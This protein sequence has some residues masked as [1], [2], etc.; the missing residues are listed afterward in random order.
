M[1][2][3]QLLELGIAAGEQVLAALHPKTS[4][5]DAAIAAEITAGLD[6]LKAAHAQVVG[7]DELEGLR[8][9]P[10]W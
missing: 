4:A 10:L 5:A 8:T 1:T 6:R 7:L 2:W 3:I 9:K